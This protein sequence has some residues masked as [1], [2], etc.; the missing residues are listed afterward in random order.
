MGGSYVPSITQQ[1]GSAVLSTISVPP[2]YSNSLHGGQDSTWLSVALDFYNHSA[3]ESNFAQELPAM[4]FATDSWFLAADQK[5][6]ELMSGHVRNVYNYLFS[7]STNHSWLGPESL[8]YTPS[9]GD[10]EIF[11]IDSTD[12]ATFSEAELLTAQ[13]LAT[14]WTNFAKHGNPSPFWEKMLWQE[15]QFAV[16]KREL[17]KKTTEFLVNHLED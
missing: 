15:R 11:L 4:N 10:E 7:Q 17:Y 14:Y 1:Q 9:H 5:S 13:H 6:V 16:E 12:R 8:E 3:G 2:K